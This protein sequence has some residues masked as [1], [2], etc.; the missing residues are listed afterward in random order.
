LFVVRDALG[1]VIVND[2]PPPDLCFLRALASAATIDLKRPTS[3]DDVADRLPPT[4]Y[5]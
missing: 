5:G 3:V 1:G 2:D 4:P